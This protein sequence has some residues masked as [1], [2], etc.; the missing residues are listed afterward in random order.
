MRSLSVYVCIS[1]HFWTN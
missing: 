1:F